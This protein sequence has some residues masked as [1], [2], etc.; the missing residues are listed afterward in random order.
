MS[1]FTS[2]ANQIYQGLKER[3]LTGELPPG[4]HLVRRQVALEHG[5]SPIPVIEA[6]LRLEMDGLVES[7][8]RYGARVRLMSEEQIADEQVFREA[9]ECEA[10]RRFARNA[11][12]RRR[13]ELALMADRLDRLQHGEAPQSSEATALHRDFHFFIAAHGGHPLLSRELERLWY[14]RVGAGWVDPQAY[15]TPADW[16][17]S[18][19]RSLLSADAAA[20]ETAM[21]AH[22]NL[23][24]DAQRGALIARFG[25]PK[26]G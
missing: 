5:T 17:A 9:I 1:K 6:L 10:A 16:H 24:R 18:L 15:P 26:P 23:N 3:I 4:T 20:A 2:A 14:W 12:A 13:E 7:E 21:R 22:V 11:P 19:A 25:S 8:P